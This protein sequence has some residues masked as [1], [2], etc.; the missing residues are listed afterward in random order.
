MNRR[1]LRRLLG[2]GSESRSIPSSSV[3]AL[4]PSEDT[5]PSD[6]APNSSSH[7]GNKFMFTMFVLDRKPQGFYFPTP[8]ECK[9]TLSI[10][11]YLI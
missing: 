8:E 11:I 2:A 7:S 6:S 1:L 9:S 4:P 10:F 5:E 3:S